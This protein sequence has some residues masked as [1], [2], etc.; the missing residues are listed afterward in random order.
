LL[1]RFQAKLKTISVIA[2][3]SVSTRSVSHCLKAQWNARHKSGHDRR[4]V[5]AQPRLDQEESQAEPR[6]AAEGGA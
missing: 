6:P 3:D 2:G 5:I 4:E 1:K